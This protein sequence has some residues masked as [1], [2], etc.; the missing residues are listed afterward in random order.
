MPMASFGPP[1]PQFNSLTIAKRLR[2]DIPPEQMNLDVPATS[3]Y[4]VWTMF[5]ITA[6]IVTLFVLAYLLRP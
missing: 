5:G 3:P 4:A 6:I 1:V 2:D